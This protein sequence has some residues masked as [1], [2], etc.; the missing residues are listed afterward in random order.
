METQEKEKNVPLFVD[1]DGTLIKTD[2]CFESLVLL[3]KKNPLLFL[4]SL[5]W[6]IKGR[7][8]FKQQLA[9]RVSFDPALLPYSEEFLSFVKDEHKQGREIILATASDSR[10]AQVFADHLGIFTATIASD[11]VV[12]RKGK[13]KLQ[14]IKSLAGDNVFDYA[15]NEMADLPVWKEARKCIV[16]N[17]NTEGLARIKKHIDVHQ[18]FDTY[19]S[20]LKT[21]LS[22]VR[23]HQFSKNS[24][25]FVPIIM[26]HQLADFGKLFDL[27]LAFVSFSFCAAAVYLLNDCIDLESDRR[28]PL[29]KKRP[30]ASGTLSIPFALTLIPLLTAASILLAARLASG[31]LFLLLLYLVLTT[32]YSIQLRRIVLADCVVLSSLYMLRIIAGGVAAQVLVSEWLLAFAIFFFL[33]LAFAKRYAELHRLAVENKEHSHGRGYWSEDLPQLATFGAASGYISVLIL[34]L[35]LNSSEMRALYSHPGALWLICPLLLY[36]ISRIWLLTYRGEMLEDPLVFAITD[37]VSYA[38]GVLTA[39]LLFFAI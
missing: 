2:M 38:M 35:Y 26:A 11:G 12:N 6:L 16:V 32:A 5:F 25:L 29:K 7:A 33:S 19:Q 10:I 13:N 8:Y 39:L 21:L 3:L 28:H 9:M 34:A 4:F 30:L 14:N 23:V 36:W 15:G 31:F 20:S 27:V 24:L 1:L 18:T 22:A 17:S 37:Q